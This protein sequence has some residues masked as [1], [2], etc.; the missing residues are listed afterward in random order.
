[1]PIP[2]AGEGPVLSVAWSAVGGRRKVCPI[3]QPCRRN[4][5]LL[6]AGARL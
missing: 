6:R 4:R 1:M 2:R 3:A 5:V